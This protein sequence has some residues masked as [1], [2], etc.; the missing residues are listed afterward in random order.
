[1]NQQL[2]SGEVVRF[3]QRV[4]EIEKLFS[5]KA[6]EKRSRVARKGIDTEIKTGQVELDF[7]CGRLKRISFSKEYQFKTALV[8]FVEPWK[9]LPPIDAHALRPRIPRY[10][11]LHYLTAWEERAKKLGVDKLDLDDLRKDQ[12]AISFTCD[13][14][15]DAIH[16]SM[17][18][19]RR[20]AGGGVWC[21]S[22][23][24]SFDVNLGQKM[25][26]T[27]DALLNSVS[28]FRDEF[29]TFA[30]LR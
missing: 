30:R 19:S 5:V 3:G 6:V 25:P 17:G 20:S 13:A 23:N 9:N 26:R 16:V 18:P 4:E 22:W 28:V 2:D 1:M 21:D 24:F 10:E 29:N 8:P 11:F 27:A 14:F 7:D 12:Y 15:V